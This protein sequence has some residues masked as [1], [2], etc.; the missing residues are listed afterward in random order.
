MNEV[1]DKVF[2]LLEATNL[3]WT[4][5]KEPLFARI[6]D[7]EIETESYGIM[8]GEKHLGTVGQQYQPF[9]N[10]QLAE[11][12]V[13]ATESL[14]IKTT[15]GGSLAGNRKVYLQAELESLHIGNTQVKRWITTVNS[16]DGSTSI[17][18]GSTNTMVICSNTFYRA[19]KELSR[20]RHTLNAK[21]R[22][23]VAIQELRTSMQLDNNLMDSFK[24]MSDFKLDQPI[25][26]QLLET[27]FEVQKDTQRSEISSKKNNQILEFNQA[28]LTSIKEQDS[29]VFALFNAVTRYTNHVVKPKQERLNYL[30]NGT[31]YKINNKAFELLNGYV[32]TNR[33]APIHHVLN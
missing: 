16:H 22:I 33:P 17:G 18:F 26:E 20:F 9:Q 15:N 4:V 24:R 11:T 14:N 8:R 21:D 27:I 10:S 5:T 13:N 28:L 19:Y 23:Q 32:E 12:I 25:V 2:N 3:N 31:G 7:K 29:T 6:G 30:M 1:N